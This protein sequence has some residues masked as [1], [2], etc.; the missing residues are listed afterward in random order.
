MIVSSTEPAV[1]RALGTVSTLPE[2]YG[3]DVFWVAQ[4]R[5][6]GVQRKTWEDLIA[7][8]GDDRL[9]R[10]VGQ[11]DVLDR[12]VLMLEGR[13]VV[14][15][16]GKWLIGRR[17]WT[18]EQ[19][20][21]LQWS[22]MDRGWWVVRTDDLAGTVSTLRTLRAWSMKPRHDALESRSQNAKGVWGMGPSDRAFGVWLL[23]SMPGVGVELARRIYDQMGLPMEWTVS[24]DE[25]AKVKGIGKK[26][27]ARL[28]GLLGRKDETDG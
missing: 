21:G 24:E 14:T 10:E 4:R 11:A 2:R 16:D 17:E 20:A 3:V 13:P 1:L 27:A 26:K 15:S 22:F 23:Q 8:V 12:R 5:T 28:Y 6:W 9:V 7:S 19:V 18:R 25:L